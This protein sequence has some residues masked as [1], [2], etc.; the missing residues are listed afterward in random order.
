M[1]T[2]PLVHLSVYQKIYM[3]SH[4]MGV[5]NFAKGGRTFANAIGY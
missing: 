3:I 1:R 2:G 4:I 5:P